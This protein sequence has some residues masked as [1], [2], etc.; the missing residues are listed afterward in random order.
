[1]TFLTP[2]RRQQ[3]LARDIRELEALLDKVE[4]ED[5]RE[6]LEARLAELRSRRDG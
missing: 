4:S 6:G 1:M 3:E 5:V 2:L